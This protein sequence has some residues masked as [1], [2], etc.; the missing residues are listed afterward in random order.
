[1]KSQGFDEASQTVAGGKLESVRSEVRTTVFELNTL[2]S[3]LPADFPKDK[4]V[5]LRTAIRDSKLALLFS[6]WGKDWGDYGKFKQWIIDGE[7]RP[8]PVVFQ[9]PVEIFHHGEK[10]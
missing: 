8:V 4:L 9:A 3:R 5:D 6:V 10:E 7:P 1:M 2:W